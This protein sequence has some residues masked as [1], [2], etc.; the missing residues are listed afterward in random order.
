M[1]TTASS[2][3]TGRGAALVVVAA[4]VV[5]SVVNTVISLVAQA[6]GA[7]ASVIMGL[8]PVVFIVFTLIGTALGALGWVVIRRRAATANDKAKN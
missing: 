6:M 7:D 1:A 4:T 3:S 8:Q 2:T 5:A